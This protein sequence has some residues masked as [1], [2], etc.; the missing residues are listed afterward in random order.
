MNMIGEGVFIDGLYYLCKNSSLTRALQVKLKSIHENQLWHRRLAHPSESVLFKF[1]TS[2]ST[3]DITCH[4]YQLSKFTRLPFVNSQSRACKPFE[5][6]HTDV[7]GPTAESRE[8][9]KYFVLFIDDFSRVSFLYLMKSKNEVFT[10]FK[11]FHIH[12]KTQF[13]SHIKVLRSD[14]GSEFMSNNMVQYLSAQ[15][16]IHQTSCV[17]TP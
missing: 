10:I 6:V 4:T 13:Q 11:D 1:F 3:S 9:F 16:I 8:G 14:N 17:A 15:G 7:W 5:M 2:V 12:V